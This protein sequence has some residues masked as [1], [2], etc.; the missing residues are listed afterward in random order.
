[1]SWLQEGQQQQPQQPQRPNMWSIL[2]TLVVRMLIIYF[3]ASFFR[4]SPTTPVSDTGSSGTQTRPA[5]NL[6]EKGTV[7]VRVYFF[8]NFF[9]NISGF[10]CTHVYVCK[11]TLWKGEKICRW[12]YRH[13]C[14]MHV[15]ENL[16]TCIYVCVCESPHS[17][18]LFADIQKLLYVYEVPFVYYENTNGI[19]FLYL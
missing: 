3:I 11:H 13:I 9:W 4:R 19:N 8:L 1:M 15:W 12:E 7:M 2:K 5:S 6:F 16:G 14:H 18:C 10:T 17:S